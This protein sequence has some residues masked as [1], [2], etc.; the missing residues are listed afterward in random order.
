MIY[1]GE[2]IVARV[3]QSG[4]DLYTLTA[5]GEL[6]TSL[7]IYFDNGDQHIVWYEV[8]EMSHLD[9]VINGERQY[10]MEIPTIE[11]AKQRI[12]AYRAANPIGDDD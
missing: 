6:D 4:T 5:K 1:K 12:D 7:D 11:E 2:E 10:F 3:W 9:V 8:S